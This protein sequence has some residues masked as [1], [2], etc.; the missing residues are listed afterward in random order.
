MID[1]LM[2]K[3]VTCAAL[4]AGIG[5]NVK[6]HAFPFEL[7]AFGPVPETL[8]NRYLG[9]TS[10]SSSSTSSYNG[11]SYQYLN[12]FQTNYS[13]K[14]WEERISYD[15]EA[16]SQEVPLIRDD[17]QPYKNDD[18]VWVLAIDIKRIDGV[19]HYLYLGN[20]NRQEIPYEPW[21]SVKILAASAAISKARQSSSGL[22][23][24]DAY[25]GEYNISDIITTAMS[26]R[27]SGNVNTTSN[28]ASNFLIRSATESYATSLITDWLKVSDNSKFFGKFGKPIFDPQTPTWIN[29]N[30]S[31]DLP[32]DYYSR[33]DQKEMSLLTIGEW[34]KR[35]AVSSSD[36]NTMMPYLTPN[37]HERLFYG[38]PE[39][40]ALGGAHKGTSIY[41]QKALTGL[42]TLGHNSNP[43]SNRNLLAK[44]TLDNLAGKNWRIFLKNGAGPSISR[45]RGEVTLASYV[46]LPELD[47]GR[48]FVIVARSSIKDEENCVENGSCKDAIDLSSQNMDNAISNTMKFLLKRK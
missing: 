34:V 35:L 25:V 28:E 32:Y 2:T 39:T 5:V 22:V 18:G 7:T 6:G 12:S 10:S 1:S 8:D 41:I 24:A 26:Y 43:Y 31:V 45:T 29:E 42:E 47:G 15:F 4:L 33:R 16:L 30:S 13:Q 21:S 17:N 37:D 23:G 48:E 36:P 11:K 46:C 3:F 40:S 20:A 27:A 44:E 38:N 9:C 14:A 19:P